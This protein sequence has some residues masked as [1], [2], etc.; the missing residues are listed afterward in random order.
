MVKRKRLCEG[1]FK[2]DAFLKSGFFPAD[3]L[4][5]SGKGVGQITQ[6]FFAVCPLAFVLAL[7]Y[8]AFCTKSRLFYLARFTNFALSQTE[9]EKQKAPKCAV[10]EIIWKKIFR[11]IA[12]F[13]QQKQVL[14]WRGERLCVHSVLCILQK[15][16]GKICKTGAGNWIQRLQKRRKTDRNRGICHP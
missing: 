15:D 5:V 8:T 7:V 2:K 11:Q 12:S 9:L 6:G 10:L 13:F 14:L 16:T 4:A 3:W 1:F